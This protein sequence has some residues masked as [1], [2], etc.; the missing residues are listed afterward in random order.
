M[1]NPSFLEQPRRLWLGLLAA[2][3]GVGL[4]ASV[5]ALAG[6]G[7]GEAST[8]LLMIPAVVLASAL[9]GFLPGLLAVLLGAVAAWGLGADLA[10]LTLF[11]LVAA[12]IVAGGELFQRAR[13]RAE[14]VNRDLAEREAHVQSILDTIP[15][16]LV[17]IGEDGLIRSFS[18]AAERLFSWTSAEVLGRNV[19]M[20]MPQP[21]KD[22][23]DGY[24]EHY[25]RTGERRIIGLGRI[26][27]GARRDGTTFPMEL[28]VGEIRTETG[29]FFTGFIRDLTERQ[30]TEARL[31]ELQGELIHVSRLTAMGEMASALAHEINQPLGAIANYLK[32][33][34]RLLASGGLEKARVGLDKAA[35]QAL[36]AGD[37]I[38]RLREFA[39]RGESERRVESLPRIVEEAA[40]LGLV[41]A[42][43]QGVIVRFQFDPAVDVVLADR[44]QIQQVVLNLLRNALEAMEDS[45][46]KDLTVRIDPA[47]DDMALVSVAD[48][49]PGIAPE[50]EAKLFQPF[51]TTKAAGMGVGLSICRTIVEAHGGKLWP[52]QTPGG[53]ATF[54][55]TLRAVTDGEL[56]E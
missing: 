45:A 32:G 53:G 24:L 42:R 17:I 54:R 40:A 33:S 22:A 48:T 6:P 39:A 38:R 46:R 4:G 13:R 28:A 12:S 9:G 34:S 49:G 3:V 20:L 25:Y 1:S 47:P 21:H 18:T 29:R 5:K 51:I 56:D 30:S 50:V 11:A 31:Q 37:I 27:V 14:G 41:G 19:S 10:A 36:R 55:F 15:D 43:E 8:P 2:G 16:A 52:E 26:V 44:V 7:L 35:E 23:H